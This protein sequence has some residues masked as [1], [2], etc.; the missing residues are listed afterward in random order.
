MY[1]DLESVLTA[2]LRHYSDSNNLSVLRFEEPVP[3]RKDGS[4]SAQASV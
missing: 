1:P 4:T 2:D 3:G